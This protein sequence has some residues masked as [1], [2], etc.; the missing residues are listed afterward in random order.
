MHLDGFGNGPQ[1]QWFQM[2][3]TMFEKP[4]LLFDQLARHLDDR[5]RPLVEGL[6]QPVGAVDTFIEKAC[7]RLG[8]TGFENGVIIAV[9][10]QLGQCRLVEL[11]NPGAVTA[12]PYEYIGNHGSRTFAAIAQPRFW[13][14]A[15]QLANHVGDVFAIDAAGADEAVDIAARHHFE[16]VE[17][18]CHCRIVAIGFARLD[19]ETFG[20]AACADTDGIEPMNPR[21]NCGSRGGCH[22]ETFG[23]RIDSFAKVTGFVDQ[24][25]D[26]ASDDQFGTIEGGAGLRG[27]HIR[28]RG[29][30]SCKAVEIDMFVTAAAGRRAPIGTVAR[31][32][33]VKRFA[34]VIN[35]KRGVAA[36]AFR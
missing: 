2:A 3:D 20:Q 32:V 36:A 19:G 6:E 14:I 11:D 7:R 27:Q 9:D 23:N 17:Q 1:R 29:I 12:A 33:M 4:R 31:C 30:G 34:G 21:Q 16:I 8:R 15:A 26:M 13:F 18:H 24:I 22:A 35:I 25:D 5:P 10:Q 28:E